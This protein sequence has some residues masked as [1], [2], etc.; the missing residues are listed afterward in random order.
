MDI[1]FLGAARTVTGSSFLVQTGG[2]R[3]LVDC[4]MFQGVGVEKF[5]YDEFD[6]DP[7]S[8]HAVLLTHSH[9]DHCGLIPKLYRYGF[10]GK[11]FMTPPTRHVVEYMLLDSAKVQGIRHKEASKSRK[12]KGWE[13]VSKKEE[14]ILDQKPIYDTSDVLGVLKGFRVLHFGKAVKVAKNIECTYLRAGHALGAASILLRIQEGGK[15]RTILFS[16]DIGNPRQL[17]DTQFDYAKNADYIV[18]ESLYGGRYHEDRK[19]NESEIAE[20]ITKTISERG[21]VIIPA[22]TYQRSQEM[23]ALLRLFFDEKKIPGNIPVYLDSPLAI[24]ITNVYKQF[25]SYLSSKIH[26]KYKTGTQLFNADNFVFLKSNRE[27]IKIRKKPGSII[28]AGHGMCVGGRVIFHLIEKL[29]DPHSSV[30]FVG[31][32]AEGTTGR[33]IVDGA[34]KV[35]VDETE[36]PVR[37]NIHRYSA[38]SAHADH[39]DLLHWLEQVDKKKVRKVFLVHAEEEMGLAFKRAITQKGYTAVV[40]KRR[41]Q[42]QLD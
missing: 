26:A 6:V 16:G 9:L 19:E 18:M 20:V 41:Q 39:N 31:Y 36:V 32:Q 12:H 37:A 24:K 14:N 23:L 30:L 4:G 5:N 38:F 1:Q 15:N 3:I 35:F 21:N 29:P 8:I 2:T 17:L 25:Y 13:I 27:S 7:K 22:F 11:V 42:F 28:L 10:R 34:K 40:P 33:E